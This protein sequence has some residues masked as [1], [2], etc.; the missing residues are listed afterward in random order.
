M[1]GY[2]IVL[3]LTG[4]A[5][6]KVDKLANDLVRANVAAASLAGNLGKVAIASRGVGTIRSRGAAGGHPYRGRYASQPGQTRHRSTKILSYGSGFNFGG[7]GGR[8]S[9]ILQPND[10]G[11]LFGMD[12]G[13][14]MRGANLASIATSMIK[15]VGKIVLKTMLAATVAPMLLGGG[16]VM[17]AMRALQSESFAGGVRLISRRHQARL[18]L[19][20]E[21]ERGQSSADF[22]SQAYG[23]D[24]ATTLSSINVL[25]GMGV[26]GTDRKLTM[27]DATGL[28]KVGGLI[29]QQSGVNFER[30]MT[31]IQQLLVQTTPH[32]R[33][34]RELLNQAPI[35]GKY[36]MRDM[37]E[38]GVKGV[39]VRTWMKDSANIMSALKRYE[40]DL[41]SNPGMRARGQISLAKQDAW[42]RVAG[43][44]QAWTYFG[45]SGAKII[46]T[47]AE[48][49]NNLL[50]TITNN[51]SFLVMVERVNVAIETLGTSGVGFLDKFLE[52]VERFAQKY[53]IPTGDPKIAR[54]R[55]DKQKA[56]GGLLKT[57]SFRA[58]VLAYA[59]SPD[60]DFFKGTPKTVL[61][62]AKNMLVLGVLD[63]IRKDSSMLANII[64]VGE[65]QHARATD[66]KPDI[67]QAN[68][69]VANW[70]TLPKSG[71]FMRRYVTGLGG[72]PAGVGAFGGVKRYANPASQFAAYDV[73]TTLAKIIAKTYI[74]AAMESAGNIPTDGGRADGGS[75]LTGFNRDRRALEI[76]FNAPIVEWTN[77]MNTTSPQETVDAV[78]DNIEQIAAAAI[79]KALL[80][81]SN[82]MSS[83]WY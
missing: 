21:F 36:A 77:T 59:T 45:Y 43:N 34:I 28:T 51:D 16:A 83:R 12:A 73:N 32:I 24:R 78:S 53:E 33:D 66:Y 41:A 27:R 10:Q 67:A 76:H 54:V 65:F 20:A 6:R 22:L 81:A 70:L 58:E 8:F 75:D 79:Q 31:N 37:A 17:G 13:R 38:Q 61:P 44:D 72:N 7:F 71:N 14:L 39:D 3:N 47:L 60:V 9:T 63:A 5:S 26:G 29:S 69:E 56:L 18:G 68:W 62:K 82:K 2:R 19:G 42:A 4:T 15:S 30:I 64:G 49:I 50:T 11:R 74:D 48:S 1:A 25:T 35:L 80:G 55:A 40:I 52:K 23:F 57:D 46:N